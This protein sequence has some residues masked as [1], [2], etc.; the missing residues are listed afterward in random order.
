MVKTEDA[1]SEL[2]IGDPDPSK[3]NGDIV[4]GDVIQPT[5]TGMWFTQLTGVLYTDNSNLSADTSSYEWLNTCED[6]DP[7][8]ALIDTGTSYITMPTAEYNQLLQYLQDYS[9]ERGANCFIST[10]NEVSTFICESG[11]YSPTESLPFVWFQ[12]GGYAFKLSPSEYM[13]TGEN[14]C[15][16]DTRSTNGYDCLGMSSLDSMGA[17]TYILG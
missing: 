17:N 10:Y 9:K 14:S 4:W 8:L 7:C 11:S 16:H 15:Y 5:Q 2:I 6:T 13:L 12:I 1:G 3:Y